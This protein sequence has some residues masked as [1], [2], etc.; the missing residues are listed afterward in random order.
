LEDWEHKLVVDKYLETY[1][2]YKDWTKAW[3]EN[4]GKC[5]YLV[6]QHCPLELKTKLNTLARWEEAATNTDVVAL[7]LIIRDVMN[8]K[9]ERDQSTIGLVKYDTALFA[10]QMESKVPLTNTITYSKHTSVRL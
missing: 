5:Y 4:K 8:N 10:T 3:A 2:T 7:L 1:K 9:K 6:L